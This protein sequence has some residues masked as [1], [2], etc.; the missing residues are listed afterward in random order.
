MKS[1]V[2]TFSIISDAMEAQDAFRKEGLTG[3]LIPVPR[4]LSAGCGIAFSCDEGLL[5][6]A[7]SLLKEEGVHTEGFHIMEI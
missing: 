6:K 4:Q 3:K 2:I 5:E 1:L 7:K